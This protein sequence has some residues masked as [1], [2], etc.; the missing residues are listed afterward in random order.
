MKSADRLQLKRTD[1]NGQ[2]VV[3]GFFARDFGKRFANVATSD[4]F[5]AA[6]VQH[7]REHLGRGRFAVRTGDGDDR[8]FAGAPAELEL[9]NVV[10]L[11]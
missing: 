4:R 10:D 2:H 3:F 1:F 5:L 11:A 9:T 8:R 7:L 6:I